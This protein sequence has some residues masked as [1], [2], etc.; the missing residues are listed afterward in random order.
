[1]IA[2]RVILDLDAASAAA[3]LG[4]SATNCTTRLSRALD[5]LEEALRVA[6]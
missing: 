2:L 4:I 3:M 1:M 5:K 6:A